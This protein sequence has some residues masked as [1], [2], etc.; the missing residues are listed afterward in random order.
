MSFVSGMPGCS[1]QA[2]RL[3]ENS[4]DILGNFLS[5]TCFIECAWPLSSRRSSSWLWKDQNL[6]KGFLQPNELVADGG[7]WLSF[8]EAQHLVCAVL[9]DLVESTLHLLSVQW[10]LHA[11]IFNEVAGISTRDT[12][13]VD[14]TKS[15][16][17]V[18]VV[19]C[20]T[21][22]WGGG[23]TGSWGCN[24]RYLQSNLKKST[25]FLRHLRST[26]ECAPNGNRSAV[27]LN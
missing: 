4:H 18:N 6:T 21:R 19:A 7:S 23:N 14:V 26:A 25:T 1:V 3:N 16:L 12:S 11:H 8:Q 5:R 20:A 2:R 17:N 13:T 22:C 15:A 24:G 27:V 9:V 10:Q